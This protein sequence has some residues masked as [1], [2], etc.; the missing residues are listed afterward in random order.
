[1]YDSI[2]AWIIRCSDYKTAWYA[3]W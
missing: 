1:M 3:W 2:S